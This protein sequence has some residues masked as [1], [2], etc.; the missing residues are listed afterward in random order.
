MYRRDDPDTSREAA[1]L[2]APHL[3]RLQ[4]EVLRYAR[5]KG[6]RGFTHKEIAR[7]LNY[8]DVS[9]HRTRVNELVR[10]GLLEDSGEQRQHG[11]TWHTVWRIKQGAP[12]AP[13]S[14]R[15]PTLI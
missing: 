11:R 6:E 13:S 15:Q 12:D 14:P 1:N 2:I 8:P 5:T 9:T 4:A 3:N 10:M 7:D